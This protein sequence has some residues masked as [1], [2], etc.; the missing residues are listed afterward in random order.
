MP[1][2]LALLRAAFPVASSW[3]YF[4][5]A[6]VCPLA[7]PVAEAVRSFLTDALKN[8]STGFR[9]WDEKRAEVRTQAARLLGCAAHEI[10]LTTS[11]SQGLITV[12]EGLSFSPGDEILIIQDDFPANQIPWYRQ[13]RRGARVVSVP[14]RNGRVELD[15]ILERLSP[16]TRIVAVPFVLFDTGQRL[17]L[18]ALGAALSDHPAL[19]CVDAIQGLGAFPLD[20]GAARIDVLSADSHKWMLGMEGIG[21]FACRAKWLSEIDSPLTSW[22]SMEE[23]FAPYRPGKAL[24]PDAR[25]FEFA[26]LPTMEIFGLGACLELLLDTGIDT[27]AEAILELTERLCDGLHER[28]WQVLSP[29][30]HP[31]DRSGIVLAR[32][33]AGDV[34]AVVSRLESRGVS[35]AARAGGVRFSPHGWNTVDEVDRLLELLP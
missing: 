3:I 32:P 1:D 25:R 33:P 5:H 31:A 6:A 35:V 27:L 34:D 18:E 8:G 26:A 15:D 12:A 17:D 2:R 23:P 11:T 22:L 9:Q 10:A 29:R 20:M 16:A 13:E 4:N 19:F 24:R 30:E 14:R 21:L 28:N 7:R